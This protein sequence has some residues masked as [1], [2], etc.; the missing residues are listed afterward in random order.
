[1]RRL[2]VLWDIDYTLVNARGVGGEL[3]T[4]VFTDLYGRPLPQPGMALH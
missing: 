1:M 2:L 3:Y 4:K